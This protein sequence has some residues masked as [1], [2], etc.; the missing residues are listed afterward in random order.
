[1]DKLILGGTMELKEVVFCRKSTRKYL[2]E[3]VDSI[4]Y[5]KIK[6]YSSHLKRCEQDIK[7]EIKFLEPKDVLSFLPF[8]AP[9]Y[10]AIYSEEKSNY[11]TNAG[12]MLE[13]LDLFIQSQGLGCCWVGLAKAAKLESNGL[14][15]VI[16]LA[17]GKPDCEDALRPV[18]AFKRK[19][20]NE[21]CDFFDEKLEP[22]R[23]APSSMNSQPWYFTHEDDFYHVF[24][25]TPNILESIALKNFNKI[26]IGCALCNIYVNNSE[27]FETFKATAAKPVNKYYYVCSFKI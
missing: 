12:F 22:A 19:P 13:Q 14:K 15:F 5:N 9:H 11:L 20:M 6:D 8:K 17:F 24:C 10:V 26:D 23:L 4:T 7:T 27:T 2:M 3:D 16:M 1:M 25:K 18:E 21:I